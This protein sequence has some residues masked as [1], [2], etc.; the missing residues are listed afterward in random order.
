MDEARQKWRVGSWRARSEAFELDRDQLTAQET[1]GETPA[2]EAKRPAAARFRLDIQ[3]DLTGDTISLSKLQEL[4]YSAS[5]RPKGDIEERMVGPRSTLQR[6]DVLA[7]ELEAPPEDISFVSDADARRE[8]EEQKGEVRTGQLRRDTRR[9]ETSVDE[10]RS[11]LIRMLPDHDDS[12]AKLIVKEAVRRRRRED[13]EI[14]RAE[15]KRPKRR[16]THED[17]L[18]PEE[19]KQR[20]PIDDIPL[21]SLAGSRLERLPEQ[22]GMAKSS[23]AL[24]E[25]AT[26]A[27]YWSQISGANPTWSE[28]A[29]HS[30]N[31]V[32][33]DEEPQQFDGRYIRPEEESGSEYAITATR[34]RV[35]ST[36]A[37]EF[38][39]EYIKEANIDPERI[40]EIMNHRY[41][42]RWIPPE[43]FSDNALVEEYFNALSSGQTGGEDFVTW[44]YRRKQAEQYQRQMAEQARRAYVRALRTP[45]TGRRRSPFGP[46]PA[47]SRPVSREDMMRQYD[48]ARQMGYEQGAAI[49]NRRQERGAQ[50][51]YPPYGMPPYAPYPYPMGMQPPYGG[52]A[53]AKAQGGYQGLYP[54]LFEGTNPQPQLYFPQTSPQGV[55][56]GAM[57]PMNGAPSRQQM[58]FRD[59]RRA[60]GRVQTAP[61]R[62][63]GSMPPGGRKG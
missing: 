53:P 5:Y 44:A 45:H 42:G 15:R 6:Y 40:K 16:F 30:V 17:D 19:K 2:Q 62:R 4:D 52:P 25:F 3:R 23:T 31:T 36:E 61:V 47:S 35:R 26:E 59:D 39:N 48:S 33:E 14:G 9:L 27:R 34:A 49:N 29:A 56:N 32:P 10:R 12:E 28:V 57:P 43:F 63:Q 60:G 20:Q 46:A 51:G 21:S 55:P 7:G 11:E 22:S 38:N 13:A 18:P 50:T 37:G 54:E 58:P 8:R 1:D 41:R 24:P